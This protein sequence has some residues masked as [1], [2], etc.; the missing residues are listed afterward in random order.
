[1]RNLAVHVHRK[2]SVTPGFKMFQYH[3]RFGKMR[4]W[5]ATCIGPFLFVVQA[6][7][8]TEVDVNN[9]ENAAKKLDITSKFLSLMI[10]TMKEIH[11]IRR[12]SLQ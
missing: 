9:I 10:V 3:L 7:E 4:L 11:L 12:M 8:L 2:H 6:R 1:M 5:L